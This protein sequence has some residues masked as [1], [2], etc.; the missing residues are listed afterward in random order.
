VT[1]LRELSRPSARCLCLLILN[2]AGMPIGPGRHGGVWLTARHARRGGGYGRGFWS[3]SA[4]SRSRR[5][6][7]SFRE[8]SPWLRGGAASA[9]SATGPD[10]VERPRR[11]HVCGRRH[12]VLAGDAATIHPMCGPTARETRLTLVAPDRNL[13]R[14]IAGRRQPGAEVARKMETILSQPLARSTHMA[15]PSAAA[16][17]PRGAQTREL[18]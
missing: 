3:A 4:R 16:A 18:S 9:S 7:L 14:R 2:P 15:R 6:G 8:C 12:H 1:V 11:S 10:S 17:Q 13:R 5:G